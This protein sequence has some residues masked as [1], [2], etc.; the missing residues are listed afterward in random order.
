[1]SIT[2]SDDGTRL[3]LIRY[4]PKLPII[5][6]ACGRSQFRGVECLP[7]NELQVEA[8]L[9]GHRLDREPSQPT[10]LPAHDTRLTNCSRGVNDLDVPLECPCADQVN[11]G[12]VE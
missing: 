5:Q 1:M 9:A 3:T 11:V 10:D 4:S 8:H 2:S 6:P 12:E 7:D